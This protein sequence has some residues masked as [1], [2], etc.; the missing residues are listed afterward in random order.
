VKQ[1]KYLSHIGVH[2]LTLESYE[3]STCRFVNIGLKTNAVSVSGRTN[4][5]ITMYSINCVPNGVGYKATGCRPLSCASRWL[6]VW[7][8][9][10]SCYDKL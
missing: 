10:V 8:L 1:Y 2:N 9:A 3:I 7:A 4:K 6:D 5:G